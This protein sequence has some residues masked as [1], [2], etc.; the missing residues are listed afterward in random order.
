MSFLPLVMLKVRSGKNISQ[1]TASTPL[2]L[3]GGEQ[4][5]LSD[6]DGLMEASNEEPGL[7]AFK[8]TSV[9]R[10]Y[11]NMPIPENAAV[12]DR[13][14]HLPWLIELHSGNQ[15]RTEPKVSTIAEIATFES[16]YIMVLSTPYTQSFSL[17]FSP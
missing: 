12:R 13:S 9:T 8:S 17:A 1:M 15:G 10:W 14:K 2:L 3:C 7:L 6:A 5:D 11:V 4:A 16:N